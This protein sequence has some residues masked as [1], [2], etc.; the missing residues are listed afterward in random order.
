MITI[1]QFT[2]EVISLRLLS[3]KIYLFMKMKREIFVPT[4]LCI[5]VHTYVVMYIRFVSPNELYK[6]AIR[7]P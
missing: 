7:V 1:I 2:A 6:S 5:L 3:N 4:K